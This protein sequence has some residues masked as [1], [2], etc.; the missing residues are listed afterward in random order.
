[1]SDVYDDFQIKP[2]TKGLG[3]HKKAISL[4]DQVSRGGVS[5]EGGSKLVPEA[6][7]KEFFDS[8]SSEEK[9][10]TTHRAKE[11][12]DKLMSKLNQVSNDVTRAS[13]SI[14]GELGHK[15]EITSSLPRAPESDI[16]SLNTQV[17]PEPTH[18][19]VAPVV[20][21]KPESK[22]EKKAPS[23]PVTKGDLGGLP[24]LPSV[25]K[26]EQVG[27]RKGVH[28]SQSDQLVPSSICLPSI[29]LDFIVVVALSLI[30]LVTLLSVTRI[31]VLSV[32]INAQ[33]D[34]ATQFSLAVLFVA[35]MQ[36][37]VILTRSFFG[38]TLGE[39]TF[40]CKMGNDRQQK[41][42]FY[43]LLVVWRSFIIALTGVITL[44]FLS[45]IIRK[46]ITAKISG[47][48]LYRRKN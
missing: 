12:L 3:F 2:L 36:M 47:L 46:D 40:N 26:K 39:W 22:V 14:E 11:T 30:F 33:F 42:I 31:E 6:P 32:A 1:M 41:S 15:V 45:L 25:R 28:G 48:Q 38:C 8:S 7:P 23:G 34:V 4:S 17:T 18:R 9:S 21:P 24:T 37:Y 27:T 10:S 13:A 19:P 35:I 16:F 20:T 44:P 5:Q 43:P 29:I